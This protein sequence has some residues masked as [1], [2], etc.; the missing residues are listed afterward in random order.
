MP[1]DSPR[2]GFGNLSKVPEEPVSPRIPVAS[3]SRSGPYSNPALS[4]SQSTFRA[5][6]SSNSLA[7][8]ASSSAPSPVPP[9]PSTPSIARTSATRNIP[10]LRAT[11]S[12]SLRSDRDKQGGG[13]DT[14]SATGVSVSGVMGVSTP[15]AG[16]SKGRSNSPASSAVREKGPSSSSGKEGQV[17][18]AKGSRVAVGQNGP[19]VRHHP[20]LPTGNAD[21]VPATLMYWSKAPVYG[22]LP[23]HGLRAH[24][25]TLVDGMAWIFGG[26]DERGCWKDVWCFNTGTFCVWSTL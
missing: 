17:V 22:V 13:S 2:A 14:A 8:L 1:V 23:I 15:V 9:L 12:A 19:R 3:G 10:N 20:H 26:C 4:H 18:A 21:P 6:A 7:S 11:S 5:H 24:S 25:V 16:K